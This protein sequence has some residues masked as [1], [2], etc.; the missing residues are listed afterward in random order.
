MG[1]RFGVSYNNFIT[2]LSTGYPQGAAPFGGS[3]KS[4]RLKGW[5]IFA[6]SNTMPNNIGNSNQYQIKQQVESVIEN[7]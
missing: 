1:D 4:T 3:V 5:F 6:V 2:E 7:H